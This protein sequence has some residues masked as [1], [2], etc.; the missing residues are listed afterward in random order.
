MKRL[1]LLTTIL[2]PLCLNGAGDPNICENNIANF[3]NELAQPLN[4]EVQVGG[5]GLKRNPLFLSPDLIKCISDVNWQRKRILAA[6]HY[7]INK[8]LNYC[9]HYVPNYITPIAQRNRQ[10]HQGGYCSP[11]KDILPGSAYYKQQARWNYSGQ[12]NETINNWLDQKMW[13][14]MDCSNYTTFLYNF[15]FGTSFSSRVEWQAGQRKRGTN[16]IS[17]NQQTEALM[18][19]HPQ[20]AGLLVCSD[21]TL[22][23][24]HSCNGHGGYLSII[25]SQGQKH[26]GSIK[27]TDL[28]SLPLFP[29]DLL[30]IA[31][32]KKNSP[33]ASRVTHVALWTGKRVGYGPNDINPSQ[34]APNGLCPEKEWMPHI[35][36]WVIT[37]SHY[38]GPDY[39]ILTPCFYLNNLWGVRRVIQ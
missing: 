39:R 35:G 8:K 7:W 30:F 29:G 19:D 21:N 9:H 34:I 28:A 22:E 20:A 23:E 17:P 31:A 12:N 36:D 26:T 11:A 3:R 38:Q 13:Q 16:Y 14:G 18:L 4:T 25:D 32:T 2:L 33:N 1:I 5:W 6:A 10:V 24:K 37:D 27:A 15:A